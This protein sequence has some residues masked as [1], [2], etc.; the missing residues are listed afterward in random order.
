LFDHS[1][2]AKF[3]VGG[4]ITTAVDH[5]SAQIFIRPYNYAMLKDLVSSGD[6]DASFLAMVPTLTIAGSMRT[7]TR[8][9]VDPTTDGCDSNPYQ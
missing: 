6:L 4:G 1:T 3:E 5:I 9:N 7:W 8:A 2:T